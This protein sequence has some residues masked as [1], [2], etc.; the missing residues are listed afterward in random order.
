MHVRFSRFS[1]LAA[2]LM[3]LAL[4]ACS[5]PVSSETHVRATG[6]I[7]RAGTID[8]AAA[9]S[10]G[11]IGPVNLAP[12]TQTG[13]ITVVFVDAE[14][15]VIQPPSG[16]HLAVTSSNANVARWL[17]TAAGAFSGRI[18]GGVPGSAQ[19][20]F[21]YMH[22]RIGSGHPDAP[23]FHINVVVAAPVANISSGESV[24]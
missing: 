21:L 16:Y 2:P 23:P 8:I 18:E 15:D 9:G 13:P 12:G 3:A 11:T 20:E 17:P 4:A 14:G 10:I 24:R 7:L 22:G 19:L 5:N 6:V 1:M